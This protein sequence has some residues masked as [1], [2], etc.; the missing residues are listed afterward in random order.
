MENVDRFKCMYCGEL[1]FTKSE[2]L[3]HE[4]RHKS[5]SLANEMMI[6]RGNIWQD[7]LTCVKFAS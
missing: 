6:S 4:D 3:K 2:C 7:N 5:I 1:L